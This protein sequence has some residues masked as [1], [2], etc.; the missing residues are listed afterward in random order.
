MSCSKRS[1]NKPRPPPIKM[2]GSQLELLDSIIFFYFKI[3]RFYEPF[4]RF[5]SNGSNQDRSHN[6][7][8]FIRG[9]WFLFLFLFFAHCIKYIK[10]GEVA[11]SSEYWYCDMTYARSQSA[12]ICKDIL[13][14]FR[15][16][17][18]LERFHMHEFSEGSLR[19]FECAQS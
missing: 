16:Y 15:S 4:I 3:Y 13:L 6:R 7:Y 14:F 11:L 5:E 18:L 19:P 9:I 8:I 17:E 12:L 1:S 2:Q 10:S